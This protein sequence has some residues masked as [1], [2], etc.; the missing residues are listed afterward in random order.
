[1][2]PAIKERS[3][4]APIH[5]GLD[6][7]AAANAAKTLA[8]KLQMSTHD[9]NKAMLNV[10]AAEKGL[11]LILEELA[12]HGNVRLRQSTLDQLGVSKWDSAAWRKVSRIDDADIVTYVE[13]CGNEKQA[14]RA[15]L[16]R[17][18]I[19]VNTLPPEHDF[20]HYF[21]RMVA[22]AKMAL[23]AEGGDDGKVLAIEEFLELI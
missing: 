15:G 12:P 19:G 17:L 16:L 3:E 10:F 1:M 8:Q 13:E 5:R 9:V 11:G 7:L 23:K 6:I 20:D 2:L 14:T 22:N 4:L 18:Y 21:K